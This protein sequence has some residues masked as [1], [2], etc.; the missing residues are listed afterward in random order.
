MAKK[1]KDKGI[2]IPETAPVTEENAQSEAAQQDEAPFQQAA[3][4]EDAGEAASYTLTAEEFKTV[5]DHIAA[6]Q[7]EKDEAVAMLQRNQADFDNYRKRNASARADGYSE[8][9]RAAVTALLP[10][11]D[12]F[13]LAMQSGDAADEAWRDGV[14][15]VFRQFAETLAKLG[16]TEIDTAGKFDPKLHNAVMQ[17]KVKGKET[18]DIL[19]VLQ[20]GY[21]MGDFIIR[22]SMVKVAE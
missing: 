9:L 21:R 5:Q 10:M 16:V 1:D 14:K 11:L 18:G 7:K 15:L 20:K 4:A 2:D 6:L 17:E 19:A 8:G 13:S 22:H 3:A 12:N